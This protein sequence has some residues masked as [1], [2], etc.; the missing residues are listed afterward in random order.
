MRRR[1]V[2]V[3]V[4]A[5][6]AAL[7]AG[8]ATVDPR[9]L[10]VGPAD[11]PVDFR[12]DP[13]STGIRTNE[14]DAKEFPETRALFRRWHRITGYQAAYE[15]GDARI[16]ARADVFRG[17]DGARRLVDRIDLEIRKSGLGGQTRSRAVL[18][19]GG[20]LYAAPRLGGYTV[21]AWRYRRVAATL[22]AVRLPTARMVAL[23]RAQQRRI[24]AALG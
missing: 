5:G 20:W 15:R 9:M 1:A 3:L 23:A 17:A 21:V 18:G 22:V 10:V 19:G 12:V 8:A 14:L 4:L 24:A 7:P 6:V 16:V 2:V 11:V 13:Q